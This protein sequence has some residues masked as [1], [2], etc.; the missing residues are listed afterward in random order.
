MNAIPIMRDP[1]FILPTAA[2]LQVS[3]AGSCC[4]CRSFCSLS[5][6]TNS[7][8]SFPTSPEF[9]VCQQ[10][11]KVFLKSLSLDFYSALPSMNW[12]SEQLGIANGKD[13][14]KAFFIFMTLQGPSVGE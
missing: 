11:I 10:Q 2:R 6:A 5:D 8:G 7:S 13:C 4:F 9:A 1:R 14:S 12:S 3:L